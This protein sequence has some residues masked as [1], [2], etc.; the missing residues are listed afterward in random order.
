MQTQPS[1]FAFIIMPHL[2]QRQRGECLA[3]CAAMLL[4]YLQLP[5][6]YDRLI[7][8]LNIHVPDGTAFYHIRELVKQ[9]VTVIYQ[10][11]GTVADLQQHLL[12][13]LPCIV[14]V[15][16]GELPYWRQ[17]SCNHVLVVVGI[18]EENVYVHDP[19]FEQAPIR[20]PIDD[21]LLA[22]MEHEERYA[23]LLP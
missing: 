16:T 13:G 18:D 5:F 19:E 17:E 22:W 11:H 9:G 7:R 14:A 15:D 4:N 21:F 23:V 2:L 6:E 10:Q 3:A 1:L 8:L 20:V 12:T